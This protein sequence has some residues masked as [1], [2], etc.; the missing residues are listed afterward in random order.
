M[1]PASAPDAPK[2]VLSINEAR[3]TDRLMFVEGGGHERV[4]QWRGFSP[5][6][7]SVEFAVVNLP[8]TK[9]EDR[10]PD[11]FLAAER[12]RPRAKTPFPWG[13]DLSAAL[14]E[15]KQTGKHVVV[16]FETTWC[17]PCHSMDEW[18]WTDAEVAGVLDGGYIGVKLD[19]D[20]AKP[21]VARFKVTGYPTILV[22]D[23]SGKQSSRALGYQSSA[24]TLALLRR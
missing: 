1:L 5:D 6:G 17:G 10:A 14:A 16:D 7:R 9:A 24:Q 20:V 22:L 15:A 3:P 13:T 23:A 12:T 4:L 21:E 2:A 11:D 8:V 19:G 18:V